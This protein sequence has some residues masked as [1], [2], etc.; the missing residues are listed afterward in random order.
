MA[1]PDYQSLMLPLLRYA[2]VADGEIT[3]N[4]AVEVLA[5]ELNLTEQDL[6]EMLPSGTQFTFVNRVGWAAT[7]MKKAGL[8]EPTRKGYY[9]ITQRGRE[10]L[11]KQPKVINNKTLEEYPEFLEFKKLKGTRTKNGEEEIKLISDVSTTTPSEALEFAYKNL[12]D[13]LADELLVMLH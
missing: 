5:Q 7:Y 10:L 3:T 1:L 2:G 8:L 9:Q 11:A 6:K 4:Q 12:R 13:E